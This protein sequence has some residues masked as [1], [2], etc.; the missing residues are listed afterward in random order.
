MSSQVGILV[1][2]ALSAEV[3]EVGDK[4]SELITALMQSLAPP[5]WSYLPLPT[6]VHPS[7]VPSSLLSVLEQ[8]AAAS[9]SKEKGKATAMLLATPAQGSSTSSLTAC[10]TIKQCFSVK[11]KGKG[12]AKELKPSTIMDE[13]IALLLQQLHKAGVPEDIGADILKNPVVQLAL[14]QVLNELDI[15]Q[16]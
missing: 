5:W 1:P 4:G 10:K 7:D 3:M 6:G 8:P 9:T 14:A 15:V 11:E 12:K 16:N 13:Q 2:A